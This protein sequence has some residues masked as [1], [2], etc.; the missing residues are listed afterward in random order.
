MGVRIY[1][2]PY[3]IMVIKSMRIGWI[4]LAISI[5]GMRNS[6]NNSV[7]EIERKYHLEDFV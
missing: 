1:S 3:I 6:Y 4:G 7:E 2:S 5:E